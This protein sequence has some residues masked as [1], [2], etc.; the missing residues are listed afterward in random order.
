[1]KG[2]LYRSRTNVMVGGVCGGLG[3]YLGIDPTL[4]RLF[5]VLLALGNGAGILIYLILWIVLPVEG[6]PEGTT[7]EETARAGG[8]EIGQ[9]AREMADDVRRAVS[10][11]NPQAAVL[12]GAALVLLGVVFLIDNLNLPWLSWLDLG[13]LWPALLILGGAVLIWRRAKGA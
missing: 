1:M 10:Q 12:I 13:T 8:D 3:Q 6:Q 2:K 11:P 7:F 9:K 4:V 5:F